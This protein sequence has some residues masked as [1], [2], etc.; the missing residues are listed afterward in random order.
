MTLD[1]VLK[2][3][4]S[5][6]QENNRKNYIKMVDKYGEIDSS[7]G[8]YMKGSTKDF[9]FKPIHTE[10]GYEGAGEYMCVVY[11][12]TDHNIDSVDIGYLKLE[13]RYYS[14]SDSYYYADS[15][16]MVTPKQKTILVYE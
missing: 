9:S 11:E 6:C 14:W 4:D 12:I 10:G 1:R 16:N 5:C 15:L 8:E 3:I 13:G 7:A 2:I